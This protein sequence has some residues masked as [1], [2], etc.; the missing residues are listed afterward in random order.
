MSSVWSINKLLLKHSSDSLGTSII[1]QYAI[2]Q[3]A[4]TVTFCW[5]QNVSEA[6]VS[7]T[8]I[9]PGD[10]SDNY[11]VDISFGITSPREICF[12][13]SKS[14]QGYYWCE[15]SNVVNVSLRP[16][17]MGCNLAFYDHR[18]CKSHL[19]NIAYPK[20]QSKSVF[21]LSGCHCSP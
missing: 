2:L 5:T 18:I 16:C 6:G 12:T 19:L 8:A 4:N 13:V 15:I 20:L 9:L 21:T 1:L 7:G 10:T 14:T 17:T 11:Q 3:A